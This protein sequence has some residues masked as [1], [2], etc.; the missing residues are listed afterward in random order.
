[1]HPLNLLRDPKNSWMTPTLN[2][3]G[4]LF[5]RLF[6]SQNKDRNRKGLVLKLEMLV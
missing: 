1:M 3:K 5:G 2:L 4:S 6:K